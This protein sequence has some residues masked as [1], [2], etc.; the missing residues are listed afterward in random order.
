MK[1]VKT[2]TFDKYWSEN[3]QKKEESLEEHL[4]LRKKI[5]YLLKTFIKINKRYG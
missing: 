1:R 5:H 4:Y 2:I 3:L